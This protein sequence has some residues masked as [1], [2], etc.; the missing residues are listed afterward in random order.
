MK[1]YIDRYDNRE[2]YFSDF[3]YYNRYFRNKMD[4]PEGGGNS[5]GS[6]LEIG[7][8][9]G[10]HMQYFT[11][12]K[13]GLDIDFPALKESGYKKVVCSDLKNKLPFKNQTF[14][15][16]DCQNVIEHIS[17]SY[18]FLTECKRVLKQG[19]YIILSTPNVHKIGF[20]FYTDY[21]HIK[22]FTSE[23]LL[24]LAQDVGLKE[25]KI[26][27]FHKSIPLIKHLY[28]LKVIKIETILLLQ[29]ILYNLKFRDN[30]TL[31]LI[32]KK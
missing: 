26:S 32:A 3:L 18:S 29:N 11:D 7:C 2:I 24:Q 10:H 16:I 27:Y 19:G 6:I 13:I 8:S 5:L 20:D 25:C 9:V 14:S 1:S 30:K 28:K 22:P 17:D 12:R 21:T 15:Y 31:I 4:S 23:S